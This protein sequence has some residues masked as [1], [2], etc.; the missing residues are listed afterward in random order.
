MG[1]GEAEVGRKDERETA[2]ITLWSCL[3]PGLPGTGG[4]LVVWQDPQSVV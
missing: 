2:R 1:E 3:L 4:I